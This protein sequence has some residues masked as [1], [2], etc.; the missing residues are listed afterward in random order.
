MEL[1]NNVKEK[2]DMILEPLQVM[3]ELS[4][5]SY[6][7]IGTKLSVDENLLTLHQPSYTQGLIR[8]WN[9]DKKQ[10]I[11]Y[12]FHAIR[13]YF[14][15]YKTQDH[16]IF[17]F[18]LE[19]AIIGL[20]KLIETYKKCDERS[21]LQTLSLYKNVLDLDNSD[22]FKDKSEEAVNM[23]KVFKNIINIY[24]DKMMRVVFNILLLM[25]ENK[26][27]QEVLNCYLTAL[28]HF[29]TPINYKIRSWIQENLVM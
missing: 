28:K 1:M 25:E 27:S 21:I 2:A 5:L 14:I 29:M 17:N 24:D 19:K 12:L 8:W 23:D 20:N 7:E 26:G 10:D 22:L 11:H 13:R 6:C 4:M 18:I 9:N 16:K 3:I 15:W